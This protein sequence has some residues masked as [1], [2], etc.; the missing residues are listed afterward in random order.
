[1]CW[2]LLGS[3][4]DRL[5][6]GA[7]FLEG[8]GDALAQGVRSKVGENIGTFLCQRRAKRRLFVGFTL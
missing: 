2:G 6:F 1:M 3:C 7:P 8:K 4:I 5:E